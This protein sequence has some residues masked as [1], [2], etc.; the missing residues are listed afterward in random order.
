[1]IKTMEFVNKLNVN[2]ANIDFVGLCEES[3]A[4]DRA[5]ALTRDKV[6]KISPGGLLGGVGEL[7]GIVY[8]KGVNVLCDWRNGDYLEV[9]P[10]ALINVEVGGLEL[11]SDWLSGGA[12]INGYTGVTIECQS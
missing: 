2:R 11:V 12:G 1:M 10:A 3:C 5:A 4:V 9:Q 8:V 7:S 6:A